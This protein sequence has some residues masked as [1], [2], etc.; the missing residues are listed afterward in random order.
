MADVENG[1]TFDYKTQFFLIV[2]II[3]NTEKGRPFSF[4]I[5]CYT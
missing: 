5:L 1:W 3:V 2:I 4:N